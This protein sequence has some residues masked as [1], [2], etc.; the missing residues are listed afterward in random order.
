MQDHKKNKNRLID[1]L[2]DI[3]RLVA[4]L[5]LAKINFDITTAKKNDHETL[6]KVLSHYRELVDHTNCIILRIDKNGSIIFL[7]KFGQDFLG[8]SEEEILGQNVVG[9]IVPETDKCGRPLSQMIQDVMSHPEDYLL[10]QNENIRKNG[11]RVWVSWTNKPIFDEHGDL[12]EMLSV[13]IDHTALR[14]VEEQLR[15]S[16]EQLEI[17]ITERTTKLRESEER[18]RVLVEHAPD[19]I[20]VYN[21][22]L[23]HFVDANKRAE[24]L[25]GC[26]HEDLLKEGPEKFY[27]LNQSDGG[28]ITVSIAENAQRALDGEKVILERLIHNAKGQDRFCEVRLVKIPAEENNLIRISYIDITERKRTELALVESETR[29]KTLFDSAQ[30]TVFIKDTKLRHVDINPA[31]VEMLG[32]DRENIIGKTSREILG[33]SYPNELEEVERRVLQGQTVENQ[34]NLLVNSQ[35]ISLNVIRFPLRDSSSQITGICGIARELL[36]PGRNSFSPSLKMP[37]YPSEAMRATLRKVNLATES[38]SIVLLTGE[39]GCGKDYIAYCIHN[40]S[41]HSIGPFYSINCAAI[42]PELA[43]SELFGHEP[44]AY[45]HAIRRKRGLLEL[46]EG[47]TLL[48]NEI[49]ELSSLMQAKLLT[50]LDT[51]SFTRLGGEKSISVNTRLIAATNRDL[52]A[53]VKEGH[54]RKDLYY[55]LNVIAIKVPPLR[56]RKEDI[57]IISNKIVAELCKEMQFM[58]IPKIHPEAMKELCRYDWPGNVREL[59]NVLERSLII[60]KGGNV[61]LH[62]LHI[63]G[64]EKP[65]ENVRVVPGRTIYEVIE[66]T[67]RRMIDDALNRANGKKTEAAAVLGMSRFALARRMAKLNIT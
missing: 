2:K 40:Y 38:R 18:F 32:I 52:W 65:L 25:F 44:G 8:Y 11:E 47:G 45:T 59:R 24:E 15:E 48:L 51:F 26:S 23:K 28:S 5:E 67:E 27:R 6:F 46:A 50:F 17:M 43:E 14:R 20:L 31:G 42:P 35:T 54:F 64:R 55:R 37:E 4:E 12:K 33:D 19:A 36:N 66:E 13:G 7:N 57:P 56:D 60:S 61:R 62:H 49:G 30:D 63:G 39:T 53:E 1:E 16:K 22:D 41:S 10:N 9:T 29:F 21:V 3:H 34:Q 58:S